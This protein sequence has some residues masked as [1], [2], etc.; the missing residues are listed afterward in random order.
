MSQEKTHK[1]T[2][3]AFMALE[4]TFQVKAALKDLS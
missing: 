3:R 4:V 1:K 2:P